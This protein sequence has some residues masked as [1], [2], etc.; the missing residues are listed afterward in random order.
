MP[1]NQIAPKRLADTIVEQLETMILEGTL[2]P[3]QRLPPE[4]VLAEQFGVSRPSLREAVQRLAAKGLLKSRQGGGNYVAENLGSSFSDPLIPLLEKHPEAHRDLLE[5]RRTLEGDCAFYAAL[6]A[7]EVDLARLG[8]AWEE[9]H[10]CYQ[11]STAHNLEEE[12]AA[13]ARFHMAIAE[14]SHNVVLLHTM[15][16]LFSMLKNNIVTNIGGMYSR[17]VQTRQGLMD[18]HQ[19]LYNAIVEGREEDARA[20]AGEHIQ[21]VQQT[22]SERS[23]T[24]RRRERALR[25]E[26]SGEHRA[27]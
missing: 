9:L 16:N 13:D 23:E 2:E 15:R 18:Q 25:R 19:K 22:I 10:A 21:F 17:E 4:R 1:I 7:T 27:P 12:G 20:I 5:F 6:R 11:N 8:K 14:A 3:G 24:A 26:G